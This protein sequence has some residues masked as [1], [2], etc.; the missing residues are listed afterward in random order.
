MKKEKARAMAGKSYRYGNSSLSQQS[1]NCHRGHARATMICV[2]CLRW[3]R[4]RRH[5]DS[6]RAMLAAG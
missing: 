6:L 3:M 5:I 4:L 2:T 1:C